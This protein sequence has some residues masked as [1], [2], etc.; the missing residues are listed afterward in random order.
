MS[1]DIAQSFRGYL[2]SQPVQSPEGDHMRADAVIAQARTE[3]TRQGDVVRREPDLCHLVVKGAASLRALA[4]IRVGDD[5]IA[6]GTLSSEDVFNPDTGH[7]ESRP[8]FEAT[9]IGPDAASLSFE[10]MLHRRIQPRPGILEPRPPKRSTG[11][12]VPSAFKS[13]PRQQS[14]GGLQL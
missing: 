8:V 1:I 14:A 10:Q 11:S 5:I 6:A 3:R 2:A 12:D 9:H 13:T 7:M 4:R